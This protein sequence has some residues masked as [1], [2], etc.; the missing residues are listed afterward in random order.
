MLTDQRVFEW[1]NNLELLR[2]AEG[3]AAQS[4][5]SPAGLTI[6]QELW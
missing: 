6:V 2:H 3:I 4:A 1:G 5:S